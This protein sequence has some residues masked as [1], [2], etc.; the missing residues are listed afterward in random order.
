MNR[1]KCFEE[2]FDECSDRCIYCEHYKRCC[3]EEE[4]L[5]QMINETLE[6]QFPE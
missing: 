5:I 3:D 4:M 2:N 6:V 1:I